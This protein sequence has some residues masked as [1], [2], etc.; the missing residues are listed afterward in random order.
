MGPWAFLSEEVWRTMNRQDQ[1]LTWFYE[2]QDEIGSPASLSDLYEKFREDHNYEGSKPAFSKIVRKL[3]SK[4]ERNLL[5]KPERGHYEINERGENV[6]ETLLNPDEQEVSKPEG[7]KD[8]RSDI[9]NYLSLEGREKVSQALLDDGVYELSLSELESIRFEILD[10][11]EEN[12][13]EFIDLLDEIEKDLSDNLPGLTLELDVDVDYY[14]KTISEARDNRNI[15]EFVTIE[16][17]VE[18][19]KDSYTKVVSAEFEC[20]KCGDLYEKEQDGDKLKSPYKCQCGSRKFDLVDRNFQDVKE[21][22]LS[23]QTVENKPLEAFIK[24]ENISEDTKQ[25]FTPGRKVRVSGVIRGVP[26]QNDQTELD[27]VLDVMS[28]KRLDR[29]DQMQE[30]SQED[31]E[32]VKEKV[33][34]WNNSP[35]TYAFKEF[36]LGLAPHIVDAQTLKEVM[37]ASLIGGVENESRGDDDRIHSLIVANPGLAKSDL[38][39]YIQETFSNTYY[40]DNNSTGVGLTATVEN[41][42]NGG[43]EIRAGKL[44]YAD[45][46]VLSVDEMDKIGSEQLGRLNTAMERGKFPIDKASQNVELNGRA[47]IIATGNFTEKLDF[48]TGQYEELHSYLPEMVQGFKDRFSLIYGIR[49][50]N[51]SEIANEM[52]QG[53]QETGGSERDEGM[54]K[55]TQVIYR[56]LA[57]EKEP[58]LTE[59]AG[60]LINK[61]IKGNLADAEANNIKAEVKSESPRM[62]RN[63]IQLTLMFAKSRL[64]DK[65]QKIDAQRAIELFTKCRCSM[66]FRE[67]EPITVEQIQG[68]DSSESSDNTDSVQVKKGVMEL[69]REKVG[70]S[71]KDEQEVIE[72][73]DADEEKIEEALK[74]LKSEGEFFEPEP[75]KVAKV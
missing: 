31:I 9:K 10:W 34:V 60:N 50:Q 45:Q 6:A 69:V 35:D 32:E 36:A 21:I 37:G 27:P 75:G 43:Y 22:T 24:K 1:F 17:M 66:D 15:G 48:E 65:A 53:Y 4:D 47:T 61:F 40:A 20:S 41:L 56:G 44:V 62:I 11:A 46:G 58:V 71:Q 63:L 19:E 13:D 29:K 12:T 18:G 42:D 7:Y 23:T 68:L 14:E 51:L 67:G 33:K 49:Q 16:A 57:K 5:D 73:L 3:E 39:E 30:V 28:F 38:Q 72:S 54:D 55:Q 70:D 25:A 26:R 64:D 52:I 2:K 59:D 8:I 74:S